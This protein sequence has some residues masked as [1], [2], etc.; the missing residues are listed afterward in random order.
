MNTIIGIQGI[1]GRFIIKLLKNISIMNLFLTSVCLWGIVDS[2]LA[3][4]S[5]QAIMAIE[6][7]LQVQLFLIMP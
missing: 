3:G 4:K 6:I 2:L 7:Q 1:T 5:E